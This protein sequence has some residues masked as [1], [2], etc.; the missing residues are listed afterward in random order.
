MFSSVKIIVVDIQKPMRVVQLPCCDL[1]CEVQV[2]S[3][4]NYMPLAD[5]QVGGDGERRSTTLRAA[6][7]SSVAELDG[8]VS[9]RRGVSSPRVRA[10]E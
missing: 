3:Q 10:C 6:L 2:A 8:P 5:M 4:T 1:E 9:R 7:I